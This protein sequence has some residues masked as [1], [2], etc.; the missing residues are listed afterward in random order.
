[1]NRLDYR[2]NYLI[3]SSLACVFAKFCVFIDYLSLCQ[4]E[5]V[6]RLNLDLIFRYLQSGPF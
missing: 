5:L 4:A 3:K 1:M 6:N 2:L